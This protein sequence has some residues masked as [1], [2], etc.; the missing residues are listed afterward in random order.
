M[1][2]EGICV[3]VCVCVCVFLGLEEMSFRSRGRG[4]GRGGRFGGPPGI[5][6]CDEDGNVVIPKKQEGPPPLYPVCV[7]VCVWVFISIFLKVIFYC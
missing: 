7:C 4:R 1:N 2:E 3:C 6:P 5:L